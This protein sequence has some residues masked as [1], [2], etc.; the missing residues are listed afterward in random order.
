M[1]SRSFLTSCELLRFY[2]DELNLRRNIT[3]T[4]MDL[5]HATFH[6]EGSGAAAGEGD[7]RLLLT[8]STLRHGGTH[9]Y[10]AVRL[11]VS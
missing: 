5:R 10:L 3:F 2:L 1:S 4:F 7:V 9:T 6:T 8:V 11:F